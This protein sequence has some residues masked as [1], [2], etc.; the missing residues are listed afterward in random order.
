MFGLYGELL[1][2]RYKKNHKNCSELPES[3]KNAINKPCRNFS[4]FKQFSNLASNFDDPDVISL[5]LSG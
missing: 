5:L 3:T 4:K 2:L 1:A